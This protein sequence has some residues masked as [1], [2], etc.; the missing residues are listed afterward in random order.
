VKIETIIVDWL[1]YR[2]KNTKGRESGII[3]IWC[4]FWWPK[5]FQN[6]YSNNDAQ[7]HPRQRGP[8]RWR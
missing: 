5:G 8:K 2:R 6:G 3:R 1:N 4:Y 7:R